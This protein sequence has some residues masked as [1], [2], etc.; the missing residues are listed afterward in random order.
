LLRCTTRRCRPASL[1]LLKRRVAQLAHCEGTRGSSRVR[2][3]QGFAH[4]L[5]P[6]VVTPCCGWELLAHAA[7][8]YRLKLA[9]CAPSHRLCRG[10]CLTQGPSEVWRLCLLGQPLSPAGILWPAVF[11]RSTGQACRA[12]HPTLGAGRAWRP[13]LFP[14]FLFWG[15]GTALRD[16]HHSGDKRLS[17]TAWN[18]CLCLALCCACCVAAFTGAPTSCEPCQ[19]GWGGCVP[20]QGTWPMAS[21]SSETHTRLECDSCSIKSVYKR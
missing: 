4:T 9:P 7:L 8:L 3:M 6:T 12:L 17:A 5:A 2:N 21:E 16:M 18:T 20:L 11:G 1:E 15:L 13:A 14:L 10:S 19:S